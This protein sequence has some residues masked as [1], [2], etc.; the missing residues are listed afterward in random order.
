MSE[1]IDW[2]NLS[3]AEYQ[4]A[5]RLFR[6]RDLPARIRAEN[7]AAQPLPLPMEDGPT[8]HDLSERFGIAGAA[9]DRAAHESREN[10]RKIR[11]AE[12]EVARRKAERWR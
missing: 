8:F 11:E 2:E 6:E 1:A 5:D 7:E 12:A 4:R 3:P 9:A 10:A